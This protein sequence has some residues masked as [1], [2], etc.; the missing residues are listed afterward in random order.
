VLQIGLLVMAIGVAGL[1]AALVAAP[2]RY[3]GLAATAAERATTPAPSG[4]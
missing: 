3:L 2:D 1:A 4:A